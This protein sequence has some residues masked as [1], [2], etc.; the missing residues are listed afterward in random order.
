M[1]RLTWNN[2]HHL[3]AW[4]DF[5]MRWFGIELGLASQRFIT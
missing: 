1:R 5:Y 2:G 3:F 4:G